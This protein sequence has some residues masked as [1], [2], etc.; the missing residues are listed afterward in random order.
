[1]KSLLHKFHHYKN[2]ILRD[3]DYYELIH[4][5]SLSAFFMIGGI[6]ISYGVTILSA[7]WFGADGMGL[8]AMINTLIVFAWA[9]AGLGAQWSVIRYINER[10]AQWVA[11]RIRSFHRYI[12]RV[13]LPFSIMIWILL[14]LIR[15]W[16]ANTVFGEPDLEQ[17][18]MYLA[19]SFPL[20]VLGEI[21]LVILKWHKDLKSYHSID[22]IGKMLLHLAIIFLVRTTSQSILGPA[23]ALIISSAS[24]AIIAAPRL[25]KWHK[26]LPTIQTI[27]NYQILK[28]SLP[29]MITSISFIIMN[30]TDI[31]MLG[32]SMNSEQVGIY[33][34]AYRLAAL[35]PFG[36]LIVNMIMAQKIAQ[37]YYSW[38]KEKLKRILEIWAWVSTSIWVIATLMF[39]LFAKQRMGIFGEEFITWTLLLQV[40]CGGQLINASAGSVWYY[41]NM[42]W[43]EKIL[44]RTV[45]I[46]AILNIA[47]NTLLI[48]YYGALWAAI[49]SAICLACWNVYMVRYIWKEDKVRTFIGG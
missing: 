32:I 39:V 24:M 45:I 38:E 49:A 37:L 25:R 35:V 26:E 4:G 16:L 9:I 23:L 11:W 14:Y 6:C 42:T 7:R 2:I 13:I 8:M 20:I 48:P 17:L 22:K 31:V 34:V 3:K 21:W 47:L 46:T 10:K 28:T 30:Q 41:L 33:Q 12:I 19:F 18:I 40:L 15:G 36:L 5:I 43:R 1:M 27:S 29:M 44:Q